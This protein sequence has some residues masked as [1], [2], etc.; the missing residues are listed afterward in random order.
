MSG[1]GSHF[2]KYDPAD[3]PCWILRLI[4]SLNTL[5]L[6]SKDRNINAT[7]WRRYRKFQEQKSKSVTSPNK[8]DLLRHYSYRERLLERSIANILRNARSQN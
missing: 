7:K 6:V 2:I 8:S 5:A 3:N 1:L 4:R